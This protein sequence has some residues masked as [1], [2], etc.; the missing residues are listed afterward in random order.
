MKPI[1]RPLTD[2]EKIDNLTIA[3]NNV[4]KLVLAQQGIHGALE[5]ALISIVATHPNPVMLAADMTGRLEAGFAV[6]QGGSL[7]EDALECYQATMHNLLTACRKAM[8]PP[9][10]K[11]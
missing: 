4:T 9:V 1:P 2:R 5:G 6:L 11:G 10:A 7:S 8:G 3:L